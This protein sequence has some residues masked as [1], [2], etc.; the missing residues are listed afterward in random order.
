MQKS[1]QKHPNAHLGQGFMLFLQGS[2]GRVHL[3]ISFLHMVDLVV[4]PLLIPRDF[5]VSF[6][7][8]VTI[9]TLGV[10][11]TLIF[12]DVFSNIPAQVHHNLMSQP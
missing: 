8:L 9:F 11:V 2:G 5:P 1:V 10:S 12:L 6:R 7:E 4:L 3:S